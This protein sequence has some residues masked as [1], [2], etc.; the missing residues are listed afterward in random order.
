MTNQIRFKVFEIQLSR[1]PGSLRHVVS[2]NHSIGER[3]FMALLRELP[4]DRSRETRS[5]PIPCLAEFESE[6]P[7]LW[8]EIA[9]GGILPLSPAVTEILE[10]W[11]QESILWYLEDRFE[12]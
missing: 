2:L 12:S 6:E 9:D 7:M 11:F 8:A 5:E 1:F 3:R 4:L 10:D